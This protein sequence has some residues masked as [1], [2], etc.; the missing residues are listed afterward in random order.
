IDTADVYSAGKSEEIIG[1]WLKARTTEAR[2]AIVATKGRFP[3]GN[4]PNDIG[5]SQRHLQPALKN[6][7]RRPNLQQIDPSPMYA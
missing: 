4:G 1:R 6:F 3:M 7:L 2:Q 5:L